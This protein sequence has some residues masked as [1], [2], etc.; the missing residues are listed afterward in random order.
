MELPNLIESRSSGLEY[1][2]PLIFGVRQ[3]NCSQRGGKIAAHADAI[4]RPVN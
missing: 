4:G 3:L 2:L 1:T